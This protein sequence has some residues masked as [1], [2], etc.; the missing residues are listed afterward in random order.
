MVALILGPPGA[1]KSTY[2]RLYC[3][4]HG[5]TLYDRDDP[6]WLSD[7]AY[8]VAAG[9]ACTAPTARVAVLRTGTTPRARRRILETTAPT[10]VVVL[11][12]PRTTCVQRVR[13][14]GRPDVDH[15]VRGIDAWFTTPPTTDELEA[16]RRSGLAVVLS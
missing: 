10:H 11:E 3:T 5:L 12:T 14:R 1:G 7:Q 2:G 9:A 16:W 13:A 4:T 6:R 8:L 15:Q